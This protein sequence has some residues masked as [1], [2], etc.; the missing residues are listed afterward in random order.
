MTTKRR[1]RVKNERTSSL[2]IWVTLEAK[3]GA[4]LT[5]VSDRKKRRMRTVV[6]QKKA[7]KRKMKSKMR[8]NLTQLTQMILNKKSLTS[9][10]LMT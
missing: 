2:K 9:K 7:L 8:K 10:D 6:T 1:E 5:E 4:F 3:A